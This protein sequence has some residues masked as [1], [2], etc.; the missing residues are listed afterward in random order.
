MSL[1]WTI[2]FWV[3]V[4]ML[5][6]AGIALWGINLWQRLAPGWNIRRIAYLEALVALAILIAV[7]LKRAG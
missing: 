1:G 3:A 7:F 4:V 2:A 5:A 6:D